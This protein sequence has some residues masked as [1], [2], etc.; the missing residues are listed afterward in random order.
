METL[1]SA[2]TPWGDF[3]GTASADGALVF[4]G[5]RSLYELADL[6][7]ESW[8]I[9]GFDIGFRNGSPGVVVYAA[10]ATDDR[11]SGEVG[12]HVV[13]AFD[14]LERERVAEFVSQAFQS[15]S[16]R[17]TAREFATDPIRVIGHAPATGIGLAATSG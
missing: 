9:I 5:S 2:A 6:D 7:R 4:R 17:L 11:N 13:T 8:R 15:F 16:V 12:E 10:D 14:I 1:G 3:V